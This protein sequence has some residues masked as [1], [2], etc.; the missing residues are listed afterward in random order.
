MKRVA[1]MEQRK[2]SIVVIT[3]FA[4]ALYLILM[5]LASQNHKAKIC[6]G[7]H[8]FQQFYVVF[9]GMIWIPVFGLLIVINVI[10][11][12]TLTKI[13]RMTKAEAKNIKMKRKKQD[14]KINGARFELN[15]SV[16]EVWKTA[17]ISSRE[18]THKTYDDVTCSDAAVDRQAS[19]PHMTSVEFKDVDFSTGET[20]TG[21]L[22]DRYDDHIATTKTVSVVRVPEVNFETGT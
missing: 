5:F 17:T 7:L 6:D 16:K 22:Q 11:R 18:N 12:R 14:K 20:S 10:Y 2:V 9:A 4:I 15:T 21:P 1:W 3:G 8:I 13:S 19:I